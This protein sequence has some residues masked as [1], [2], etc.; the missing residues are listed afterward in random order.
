MNV[1]FKVVVDL[2]NYQAYSEIYLFNMLI[3]TFSDCHYKKAHAIANSSDN[4]ASVR[5]L[6]RA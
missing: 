6:V 1:G 4:S 3:S 5:L 2:V